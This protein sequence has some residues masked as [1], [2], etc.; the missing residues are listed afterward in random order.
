MGEKTESRLPELRE[1]VKEQD[2]RVY[3]FCEYMLY[4]PS[5]VAPLVI[6]IFAEFGKVYRRLESQAADLSDAELRIR[7]FQVA[8][9]FIQRH[10]AAQEHNLHL[11][12][13]TRDLKDFGRDLLSGANVD[14]QSVRDQIFQRI[15]S[16]DADLR[17]PV[18]LRDILKFDDEQTMQILGMRWGVYRHRLN[19]GRL[20]FANFLRGRLASSST[21][22]ATA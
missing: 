22:E 19:R 5:L 17:A 16:L 15:L 3:N 20:D 9:T 4:D 10:L 11:G 14:D 12:R 21:T 13:D 6:N 8:W 1:I 7:L 2:R 18:V